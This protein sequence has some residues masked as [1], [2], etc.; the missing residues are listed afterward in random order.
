LQTAQAILTLNA[1]VDN[2]GK[3]GGVYL[4]PLAPNE[5]ETHRPANAQEMTE[6]IKKMKGGGVK[7]LFVHGVNPL[8]ELPKALGFESAL[9]SVPQIIS[10][11]T[12][13][14]ETALQA[15]YISPTS[16]A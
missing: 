9:G 8:F 6:L 2:F 5:D 4:S 1:V 10:F 11:A 14:D 16:L 12:F 15:D 13:P 3:A 7:V